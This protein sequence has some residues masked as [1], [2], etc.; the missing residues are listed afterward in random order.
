MYDHYVRD[1]FRK[2]VISEIKY[3]DV[4]FFYYSLLNHRGLQPNTLDNIHTVLHPTFQMAVRDN[5]IRNNPASGVM[6][7]IKK[8]D[9]K[10]KGVRHALTL[11]QQRACLNYIA[12]SP[13]YCHWLP[14][15]TVLFGT[16]CRIGEMIG[17][18]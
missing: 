1:T 10:N 15:F 14:L 3:S 8:K 12:E 13:V 16:G 7:E 17:L 2:R 4:R 18:R 5:V 6:T 9:G 11:E